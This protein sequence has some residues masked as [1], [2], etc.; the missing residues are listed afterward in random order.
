MLI[1]QMK[2]LTDQFNSANVDKDWDL[3]EVC[4][5]S[6]FN[7]EVMSMAK[8]NCNEKRV[9]KH[10]DK[11]NKNIESNKKLLYQFSKKCRCANVPMLINCQI[12][13]SLI[14]IS[15]KIWNHVLLVID[16]KWNPY[17]ED[18]LRKKKSYKEE[19]DNTI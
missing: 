3:E 15:W 1:D 6:A 13:Q 18:G 5:N 12:K 7:E 14:Y 2:C 8:P 10:T 17:A 19:I 16:V 9:Q 11:L 4:E